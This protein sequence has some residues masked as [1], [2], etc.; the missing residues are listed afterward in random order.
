M[1]DYFS[2]DWDDTLKIKEEKNIDHSSKVFLNKISNLLDC[3]APFKNISKYKL[4]FKTKPWIT[5]GL[6]KSISIK[7]KLLTKYIK[8]KDHEKKLEL[9]NNY[10]NHRNLLSTLIKQS[11]HK[12]F[13]KYFEDNWNNMKNTWKGIK[14]I[15][16]LNNLSSDI[17]ITLS[18]NDVTISD[19][20]D[21]ANT[22]NNYFSSIAKKTKD[23]IN[24]SHKH[25]SDYLSDK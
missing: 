5:P 22:F 10:K 1:L 17:P 15:I 25:Y 16:T 8:M 21:I 9:H 23:N 19:P 18:V 24:Y 3:Y 20:C 7:N 4:K 14:N 11:K 13:N 12:Y 2:I 6:Q